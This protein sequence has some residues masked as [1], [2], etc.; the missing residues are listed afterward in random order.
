V[1]S[2][3]PREKLSR[4]TPPPS[5]KETTATALRR[6]LRTYA[7]NQR[8]IA[9]NFRRLVSYE[10]YPDYATHLIHP[11]PAKLLPHIPRFFL[12][13]DIFSRQGDV[14]LDPF[15]GS[16]TVL[17][18]AKLAGRAALGA[19]ANPLA[20][21]ITA[22]KVT[23][24]DAS[25]ARLVISRVIGRATATKGQTRKLPTPDV[26]N[27]DYWFYPHVVRQLTALQAA[28][29]RTRDSKIRAFL[30]VCF[31]VCVRR[32]S[33]ADPRLSVPVRL[34]GD[35]YHPTHK[36]H[37]SVTRRLK[38]LKRT[39]VTL[40]FEN[41]ARANLKRLALLRQDGSS[42]VVQPIASDARLLR[43][44]GHDGHQRRLRKNSVQLAITSP[45][46]AGA[47]K[48]V[49]ASSLSLGWLK[50]CSTKNLRSTEDLS[51]GREH[52]AKASYEASPPAGK[53]ALARR[54]AKVRRENPLRAHIANVYL[55]EMNEAI[56][57]LWRV[58]KP[59]GHVVFVIGD[60]YVSGKPFRTSKFL[61]DQFEAAG[62]E[63][64]LRL[65]DAIHSRGLMTK[66]NKTA[67]VIA[68]EWVFLFHKPKNADAR[69]PG[70]TRSKT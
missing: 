25:K 19:D 33:R 38:R 2:T 57:E 15:C 62:F 17:L 18:E 6:L 28:I 16:G 1:L 3:K 49:R 58:V 69:A 61:Q 9:V 60:N 41:I 22:V 42:A 29:L 55:E 70:R 31:S 21:L 14:V 32:V 50:L 7:D 11:Y 68:R 10:D 45:P 40:I 59:G 30:L 4:S 8:P 66:R 24:V 63:T 37:T 12:S 56:L 51:I 54:L 64:K 46:Y 65:Q 35:E 47:Q 53:S 5:G 20:R 48:Y 36:L 39:N 44:P 67:S 34:R 52:F 43:F 23:P 27:L 13:N 26:V